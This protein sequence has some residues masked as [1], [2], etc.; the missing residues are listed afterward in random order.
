MD[1]STQPISD[2]PDSEAAP[3]P[4]PTPLSTVEVF[5]SFTQE[6]DAWEIEGPMGGIS[7]FTI[8]EGPP[9]YFLNG[10]EGNSELFRLTAWLLR[11]EFRCILFD[12]S[13]PEKLPAVPTQEPAWVPDVQQLFAVADWHHDESFTAYGSGY[14]GWLALAA[15]VFDSRR[16]HKT[17]LQGTYIERKFRLMER[18]LLFLANRSKRTLDQVPGWPSVFEQN[19]HSW[20]PPFDPF[21]WEKFQQIAGSLPVRELAKRSKFVRKINLIDRLSEISTPTLIISTEGEGRIRNTQHKLLQ[22]KLPDCQTEWLQNSGLVP[23]WT[24]PHRVAKLIR[25]F[26][27]DEGA[28]G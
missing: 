15:M 1:S 26:V 28:E 24:H 18:A 5:E 23:H 8:G 12:A 25:E 27:G 4:C 17:I 20:F 6:S 9:L 7:G 3:E 19:H 13:L 10:W 22:E 14:G 16:F 21:R 11:E 2:Q